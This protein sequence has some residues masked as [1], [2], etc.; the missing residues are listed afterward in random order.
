[1]GTKRIKL[2]YSVLSYQ[3]V[4]S[5]MQRVQWQHVYRATELMQHTTH[6][7]GTLKISMTKTLLSLSITKYLM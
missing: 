6:V 7:L 5:T 2:L 4:Y 1:M 3:T